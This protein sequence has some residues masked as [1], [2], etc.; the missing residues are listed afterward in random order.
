MV[1]HHMHGLRAECAANFPDGNMQIVYDSQN[2]HV[3]EY[4]GNDEFDSLM[5][6]GSFNSTTSPMVPPTMTSPSC[7]E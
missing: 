1:S 4:A 2:D 6:R 3:I 5:N 7:T